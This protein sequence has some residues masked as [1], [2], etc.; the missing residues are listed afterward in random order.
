[1]QQIGTIRIQDYV[2]LD[3]K[4]DLVGTMQEIK[5]WICR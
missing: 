3:G 1:M 2:E 4:G 5:I